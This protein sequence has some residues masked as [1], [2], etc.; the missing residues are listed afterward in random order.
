MSGPEARAVQSD[1]VIEVSDASIVFDAEQ[2]QTIAVDRVSLE[3]HRGEF[4]CLL[5]PSGCGKSTLL[6]A[7]AGFQPLYSGSVRVSG[8][9]V[10][11]PGPNRGMVFQ[12]P[13]LFPW[14]SVRSNI[15]HGPS[16]AGKTR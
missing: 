9:E 7:I 3:V 8:R 6:N 15:A 12:Q 1:V 5:G 13:H 2:K 10:T 11:A 16:V 14:K 4:I